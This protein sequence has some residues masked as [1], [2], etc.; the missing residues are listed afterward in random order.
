MDAR[1]YVIAAIMQLDRAD[2]VL[3]YSIDCGLVT[4]EF[5]G[6]AVVEGT[7]DVTGTVTWED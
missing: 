1:A 7:L 5:I 2:C 4:V 3:G 6:G